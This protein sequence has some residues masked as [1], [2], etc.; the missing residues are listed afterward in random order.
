MAPFA[1]SKSMTKAIRE[2]ASL[3]RNLAGDW[4]IGGSSGLLLQG[5]ALT[6]EPRDLD[7]YTDERFV[8]IIASALQK[9]AVDQPHF[10]ETSMYSSILS[11]YRIEGVQIELVG[12]FV[13][14]S[15]GSSYHTEVSKVMKQF[16]A[17]TA[18]DDRVIY[19]TPLAHELVFNIL[20]DR[21][22]R[23]EAIAE[24]M[25]GQLH[26]YLPALLEIIKRNHWNDI[27][28]KQIN[29]LLKVSLDE[30]ECSS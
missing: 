24:K 10:S 2:I 9:Y 14:N 4:I 30:R 8:G 11:H 1:C 22:D 17:V 16:N 12:N 29:N 3:L 21:A 27:H 7:I 18:L 26:V 20:R 23:Y 15:G 6:S 25:R 5:V 28:L 19:L 13:V